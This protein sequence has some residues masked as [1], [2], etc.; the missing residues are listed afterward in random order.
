MLIRNA[1]RQD[2]ILSELIVVLGFQA[3]AEPCT[4]PSLCSAEYWV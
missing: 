4:V 3:N 2:G 1:D